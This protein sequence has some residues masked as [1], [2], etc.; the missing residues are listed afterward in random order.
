MRIAFASTLTAGIAAIAL[1]TA[2]AGN[3]TGSTSLVPGSPALPGAA[4]HSRERG[5]PLGTCT[6]ARRLRAGVAHSQSAKP[7]ARSPLLYVADVCEPSID[8]LRGGTY[9]ELGSITSEVSDPVDVFADSKGNLYA[10]NSIG[11]NFSNGYITEYAADNWSSPSFTYNVNVAYPFAVT[12]DANGNVYEGDE[13]GYI[14]EYYQEQNVATVASCQPVSNGRIYGVA[15]DSENDV[16]ATGATEL[17]EYP[18]GL[19]KCPS[20]TVLPLPSTDVG[21]GIAVDKNANLLIANGK[22]VEV[23]DAPSYSTVNATI[24]GFSCAVNVRLNKANTLAFVTDTCSETVTL[25]NYPSLTIAGVLGTG[26]GLIYPSA[27]V[28]HPNAVY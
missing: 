5:S 26:N 3:S 7:A 19:N 9:Y 2:C 8:V 28:E 16:F 27:A 21:Q 10:A 4:L 14:N 23:V 24:G 18:G 12:A 6:E 13:N 20:P 11:P 25:V 15:V 1:L 22:S 17:F